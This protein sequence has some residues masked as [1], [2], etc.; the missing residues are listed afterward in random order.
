[1]IT[2]LFSDFPFSKKWRGGGK[3]EKDRKVWVYISTPKGWMGEQEVIQFI[4]DI[5]FILEYKF[6]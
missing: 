4:S 1:M 2:L 6:H 5:N 3:G